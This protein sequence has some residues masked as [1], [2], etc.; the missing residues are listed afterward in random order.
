[1][2]LDDRGMR[3]GAYRASFRIEALLERVGV[4]AEHVAH[5]LDRDLAAESLISRT[6]DFAHRARAEDVEHGVPSKL[7]RAGFR[8]VHSI[9]SSPQSRGGTLP[10]PNEAC[11][12]RCHLRAT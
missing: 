8:H 3:Q 9:R 1:V 11:A 4:I 7:A 12:A 10:A 5:R 6:K 2:D